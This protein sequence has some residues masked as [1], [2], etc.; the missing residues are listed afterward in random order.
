MPSS[1]S[2]DSEGFLSMRTPSFSST[3]ELVWS[4]PPS[5]AMPLTTIPA[6][7]IVKFLLPLLWLIPVLRDG[8]EREI[9]WGRY[10]AEEGDGE[11]VHVAR[12]KCRSAGASVRAAI[13]TSFAAILLLSSGV[14]VMRSRNHVLTLR[15]SLSLPLWAYY[16]PI[17]YQ[18]PSSKVAVLATVRT[19]LLI[20]F[21]GTSH[22]VPIVFFFK[23]LNTH[24]ASL[25]LWG[26]QGMN[27]SNVS[28]LV[29]E[30]NLCRIWYATMVSQ[31]L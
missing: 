26:D 31:S 8:S 21:W 11:E 13:A 3:L 14:C 2:R 27:F 9:R 24:F 20:R 23:F 4:S 22:S 6:R 17:L 12:G 28:N 15:P 19:Q 16:R 29:K 30:I 25:W 7:R 10:A 5:A 18:S 1:D